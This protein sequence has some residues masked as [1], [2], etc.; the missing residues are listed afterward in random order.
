MHMHSEII[1]DF[2]K[3]TK[4]FPESCDIK[5]HRRD[6]IILQKT[7]KRAVVYTTLL[8]EM[9]VINQSRYKLQNICLCS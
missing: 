5:E 7:W 1:D 4:I 3:H 6:K 9:T 2:C 8:L